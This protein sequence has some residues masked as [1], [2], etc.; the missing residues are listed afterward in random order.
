MGILHTLLGQ[1]LQPDRNNAPADIGLAALWSYASLTTPPNFRS[2]HGRHSA[3]HLISLN[4]VHDVCRG[5]TGQLANQYDGCK[6][7]GRADPDEVEIVDLDVDDFDVDVDESNSSFSPG[8]GRT[9]SGRK[10]RKFN[11]LNMRFGSKYR[12][13]DNEEKLMGELM[14]LGKAYAIIAFMMHG[15]DLPTELAQHN[16]RHWI[17][18]TAA[19]YALSNE[20]LAAVM[21]H[22]DGDEKHIYYHNLLTTSTQSFSSLLYKEARYWFQNTVFLPAKHNA[23]YKL[24]LGHGPTESVF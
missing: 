1:S 19:E 14:P 4:A 7:R 10:I 16:E 8:Q 2:N 17:F 5:T 21:A 18:V 24:H 22:N 11:S 15:P 23:E 9:K 12:H 6:K 3:A 13:P 20:D